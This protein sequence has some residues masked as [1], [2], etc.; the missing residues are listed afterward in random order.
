MTK[1]GAKVHIEVGHSSSQLLIDLLPL[2]L[3]GSAIAIVLLFY[4]TG[5]DPAATLKSAP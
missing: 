4:R 2:V 1:T 3:V 5:P